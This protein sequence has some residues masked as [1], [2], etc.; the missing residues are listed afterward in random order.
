MTIITIIFNSLAEQARN[1]YSYLPRVV[2]FLNAL[3]GSTESALICLDI[4]PVG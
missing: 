2:F 4:V 1:R 3:A